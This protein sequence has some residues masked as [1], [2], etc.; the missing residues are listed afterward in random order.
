MFN[1]VK[2]QQHAAEKSSIVR[3]LTKHLGEMW[4]TVLICSAVDP[5]SLPF[6]FVGRLVIIIHFLSILMQYDC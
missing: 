1:E 3:N 6:T 4:I 5:H 2:K